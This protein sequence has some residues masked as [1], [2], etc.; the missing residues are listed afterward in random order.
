MN[1]LLFWDVV[2]RGLEVFVVCAGIFCG[3][4]GVLMAV[5]FWHWRTR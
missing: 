1:D 3:I 2:R 5:Y 4:M